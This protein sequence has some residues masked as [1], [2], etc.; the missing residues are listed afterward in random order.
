MD[1]NNRTTKLQTKPT[2]TR[3]ELK[4]FRDLRTRKIKVSTLKY[5]DYQPVWI[6][7]EPQYTLA[8]A[9]RSLA[10]KLDA[11]ESE[12]FVKHNNFAGVK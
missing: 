3:T 4:W 12:A 8:D 10:D 5:I 6:S 2:E 11:P 1:T 7:G 9:L